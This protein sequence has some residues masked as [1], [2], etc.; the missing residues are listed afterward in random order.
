[1]K[2]GT[3]REPMITCGDKAKENAAKDAAYK[4]TGRILL[5]A[6]CA[7]VVVLLAAMIRLY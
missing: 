7:L 4:L 3:P 2:Q 6:E 1:M 5:I